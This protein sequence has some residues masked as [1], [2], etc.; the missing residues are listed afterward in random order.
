MNKFDIRVFMTSV[1]RESGEEQGAPLSF[2]VLRPLLARKGEDFVRQAYWQILNREVDPDG[3]AAFT[4]RAATLPGR[5]IILLSLHLSPERILLP[6]WARKLV[7][8]AGKPF[9]K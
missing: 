8:L 4:G 5:L 3:L 7:R 6:D 2:G 1:R 9:Q